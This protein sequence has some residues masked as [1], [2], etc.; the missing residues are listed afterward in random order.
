MLNIIS[1]LSHLE[2]VVRKYRGYAIAVDPRSTLQAT[3]SSRSEQRVTIY[4]RSLLQM[5]V[6]TAL[7]AADTTD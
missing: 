1:P 2:G 6:I 5:K 4:P 7:N 3:Y